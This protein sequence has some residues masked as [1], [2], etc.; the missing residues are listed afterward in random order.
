LQE[1]IEIPVC[2][3][4]FMKYSHDEKLKLKTLYFSLL[5]VLER[6]VEDSQERVIRIYKFF[7]NFLSA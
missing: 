4:H 5:S 6:R 7:Y 1:V 3:P 2:M